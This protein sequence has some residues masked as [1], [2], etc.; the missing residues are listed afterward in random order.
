MHSTHC[1]KF[2]SGPVGNDGN[3]CPVFCSTSC[4]GDEMSCY[5]GKD[6]NGCLQPEFCMPNKGIVVNVH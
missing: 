6:W 5:G 2:L 1:C 4:N 3:E